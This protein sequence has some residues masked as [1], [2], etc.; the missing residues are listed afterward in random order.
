MSPLQLAN[1]KDQIGDLD[2]DNDSDMEVI[3]GWDELDQ[4]HRDLI[5]EALKQG[6]V[7]DDVWKGVSSVC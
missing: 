6:H 5:R 3:D 7:G 4:E 2:Y 1:L